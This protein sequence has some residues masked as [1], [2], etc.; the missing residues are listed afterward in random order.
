MGKFGIFEIT[1]NGQ[2][3]CRAFGDNDQEGDTDYGPTGCS[4]LAQLK[5]GGWVTAAGTGQQKIKVLLKRISACS[6]GHFNFELVVCTV[7]SPDR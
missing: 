3:I 1:T 7:L 2:G 4:G 5:E 6:F